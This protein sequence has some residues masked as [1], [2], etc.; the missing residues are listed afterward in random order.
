MVKNRQNMKEKYKS[1]SIEWIRK[2]SYLDGK[3]IP[4]H[5][6]DLEPRDIRILF[7]IHKPK[8]F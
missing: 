7:A 5:L 6:Q 8:F 4:D 2:I 3:K 1:T